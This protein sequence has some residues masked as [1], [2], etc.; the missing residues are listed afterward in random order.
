MAKPL[1]VILKKYSDVIAGKLPAS[2]V[3]DL[4]LGKEPGVDYAPKMADERE[5]VASH[6]VE[7]HPDR[8]G[9]GPDVYNGAKVK[10]AIDDRHGHIPNPKSKNQYTQANEETENDDGW[11][12]HKEM[13]GSKAVSKEDWKKGWRLNS[14]G[15]KVK[16]AK[17]LKEVKDNREYDYEGEMAVTKLKTIVRAAEHLIEMMKPNTNLPEWVQSKIVKAE[18]Y[19]STAHDYLMSEMNEE[20]EQLDENVLG[21][22]IKAYADHHR[23]AFDAYDYGDDE[24]GEHHEKRAEKIHADIVKNHGIEAG[25]HARAA[26]DAA[27]YGTERSRNR[28][29]DTLAGG[30]RKYFSTNVT[31][32]GKIPK[33]TQT[34]MKNIAASGK[35]VFKRSLGKP[36]G[37][38]PEEF[39]QLVEF[40]LTDEHKKA[41]ISKVRNRYLGGNPKFSFEKNEG[42]SHD[43]KVVAAGKEHF[44]R[45]THSKKTGLDV[46]KSPY[47]QSDEEYIPEAKCNMTEAG[48]MCEVHG[49]KACPK[50]SDDQPMYNKG[51]K[52]LVDK[53]LKERT[54]TS[55]EKKKEK[56]LKDKY[57][58][59]DMKAKM[60]KQY[61]DE[62]GKSVYFAYIRK[63]AM[64]KE[65]A[66]VDSPIRMPSN[67]SNETSGGNGTGNNLGNWKV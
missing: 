24:E 11:Y 12:A 50:V 25:H 7:K 5:F 44:H 54:M 51:K 4:T 17:S 35:G 41:A 22:K 19:I 1:A 28:K 61:G 53:S 63:K 46:E 29:P 30:L 36:K 64:Q 6:S 10:Q 67:P 38:L 43:L 14:K 59:S 57:D 47:M 42:G 18:D 39:E 31:K 65:Q 21:A 26:G 60:M 15:E 20:T 37:K 32:A 2:E 48:K 3:S 58:D 62:K 40:K 13:H 45:I 16:K 23:S 27:I 8:V 52:L 34:G 55:S 49:M 56:K 33:N 9:N 66:P